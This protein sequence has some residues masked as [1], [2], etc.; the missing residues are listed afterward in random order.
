MVGM[1]TF[2]AFTFTQVTFILFIESRS[3]SW[4][5]G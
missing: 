5:C 2:D 1:L 4:S 3:A